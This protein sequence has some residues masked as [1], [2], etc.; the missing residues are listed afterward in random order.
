VI[1]DAKVPERAFRVKCPKCGSAVSLPGRAAAAPAA[2]AP[3]MATE[4]FP[5]PGSA[6]AAAP[7]EMRSQLMAE[8]RR[9]M[10]MGAAPGGSG[11]ALVSL[12]DRGVAGTV[13]VTLTRLGYQVDNVEDAEEGARLLE[14]GLY[15]LVATARSGAAGARGENL[16]QR[17][18]RL[19][20]ENR[21]RLVL[22]LVG[23][24]YKT[25]DGIQ[26][27][28]AVADLVLNGRDIPTADSA[29]RG[30]LSERQRLYQV[31]LDARR[32]FEESAS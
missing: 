14:Q 25:A 8:L 30:A 27:W 3:G 13:T 2:P 6:S 16:Y 1:D 17:I 24:E 5:A 4:A 28:T 32:R 10:G 12:S 20:P 15:N 18:I 21:R 22:V 11:R 23:D 19:S 7:D 29:I 31:F 26:A 9:E